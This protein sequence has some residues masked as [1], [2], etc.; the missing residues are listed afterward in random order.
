[1][2]IDI[3]DVNEFD[4]LFE[5][6]TYDFIISTSQIDQVVGSVKVPITNIYLDDMYLDNRLFC[7]LDVSKCICFW[8]IA[9]G[10]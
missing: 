3:I 5:R 1:M 8:Q 7:R 2:V 6:K 10:N 9:H 4:P